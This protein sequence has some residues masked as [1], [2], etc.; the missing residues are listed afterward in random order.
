LVQKRLI[1]RLAAASRGGEVERV[2]L[3][4]LRPPGLE[5]VW[6]SGD[7]VRHMKEKGFTYEVLLKGEPLAD[8]FKIAWQPAVVV[9][10]PDGR[11]AYEDFGASKDRNRKLRDAILRTLR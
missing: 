11:I 3:A 5:H 2:P 7:P 10:G 1:Q 4:G 6:E 8:L 9:I